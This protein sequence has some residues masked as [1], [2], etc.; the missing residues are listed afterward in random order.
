MWA[1]TESR[2][3]F[4][5]RHVNTIS[6]SISLARFAD[7]HLLARANT[8]TVHPVCFLCIPLKTVYRN[9]L[10]FFKPYPIMAISTFF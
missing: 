2:G 6:I 3:Q 8:H 4:C 9:D 7:R 10:M 5:Q 1:D